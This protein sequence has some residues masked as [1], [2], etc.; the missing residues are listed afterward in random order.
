MFDPIEIDDL[1]AIPDE[2]YGRLFPTEPAR[3]REIETTVRDIIDQVRRHG[4]LAVS[5][6][7]KRFDNVQLEAEEFHVPEQFVRETAAQ[8]D[9]AL[10]AAIDS[11]IVNVTKF[12]T[13]QRPSG[14]S[15]PGPAGSTLSWNYRP[16]QA[17]GV[18]VPGGLAA[19]PTSLIMNVVPARIAGVPRIVVITPPGSVSSNPAVAYALRELSIDEIVRVGGAQGIAAAAFGTETINPVDVI[20]GPGNAFVAEA[21]RQVFGQVGIDSVAGPSEVVILADESAPLDYIVWDLL[22]Q[23]EHDPDARVVL[24]SDSLALATAVQERIVECMETSPRAEVMALAIENNSAN[25]VIPSLS[26]AKLLINAIAPEHLQIMVSPSAKIDPEE[27]VAGAI[28]WGPHSPTAIGDY[29]AGPNH[30]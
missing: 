22:A 8:A 21:K 19:Y 12:H 26:L 15:M 30:V 9:D 18:Y 27:L 25:C 6:L 29:W 10:K 20:V 17:V 14:F 4:D 24:I 3:T 28:F 1:S 23:A 5:E 16:V 2:L 11:M 7:T 13:P